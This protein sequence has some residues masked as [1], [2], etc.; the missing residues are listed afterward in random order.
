MLTLDQV[1]AHLKLDPTA[2]DEDV[3]LT[4]ILAAALG[5]FRTLSKR[6]WPDIG[7]PV[8]AKASDPTKN[9]P[10]LVFARYIDPAALSPDEQAMADQY[11]LLTVG[12][13]YENRQ[14]VVVGLNL[15]EVPQTAQ[16]LMN[17][18]REPTI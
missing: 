5:T 3:L 16:L 15:T 4:G 18:L 7:E 8:L 12:H 17:I 1:K 13:W 6:R 14:T 11:I 10:E 2:P 9:P